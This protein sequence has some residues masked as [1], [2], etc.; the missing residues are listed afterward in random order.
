ME[1]AAGLILS[2]NLFHLLT[3][4]LS[5]GGLINITR[6]PRVKGLQKL[7]AFNFQLEKLITQPASRRRRVD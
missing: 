5:I 6:A 7:S 3:S 4:R 2:S 1:T